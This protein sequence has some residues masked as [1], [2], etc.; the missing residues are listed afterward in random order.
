M[1]IDNTVYSVAVLPTDIKDGLLTLTINNIN[2]MNDTTY[3]IVIN[4]NSGIATLQNSFS[5]CTTHA[6]CLNLYV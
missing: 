1:Y 3:D 2:L 5:K 4:G 6:Y